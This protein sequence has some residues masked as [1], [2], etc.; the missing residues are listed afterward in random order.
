VLETERATTIDFTKALAW[1]RATATTI[2]REG[3][4]HPTFARVDQNV[5]ATAALLDTLPASSADRVDKV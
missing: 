2:F 1:A 3:P 5:A 4:P